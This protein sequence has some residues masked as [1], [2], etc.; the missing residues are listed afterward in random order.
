AEASAGVKNSQAKHLEKSVSRDPL[1]SPAKLAVA[2]FSH[3][4]LPAKSCSHPRVA[5]L[6][7]VVGSLERSE[8]NVCALAEAPDNML[9]ARNVLVI[10]SL[11]LSVCIGLV[12]ARGKS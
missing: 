6:V 11:A 2:K 10:V 8:Q 12:I 4:A 9:S 1:I 5:R 3:Y 7:R